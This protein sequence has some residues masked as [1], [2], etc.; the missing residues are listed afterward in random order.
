MT[1]PHAMLTYITHRDQ[2]LMRRR[3]PLARA[4]LDPHLD[5]LRHPRRR[6]LAVVRAG[7]GDPAVR[8]RATVPRRGRGGAGRRSGHRRSS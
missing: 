2:R 8:R 5:D 4:A 6:W 3:Q 1:L 7:P